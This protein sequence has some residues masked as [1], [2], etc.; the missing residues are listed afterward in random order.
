M[1]PRTSCERKGCEAF[2]PR[3]FPSLPPVFFSSTWSTICSVCGW[4]VVARD[5][6]VWREPAQTNETC[7]A[8]YLSFSF[9]RSPPHSPFFF[10]PFWWCL[11]GGKL[12]KTREQTNI[13]TTRNKT[14]P[15]VFVSFQRPRSPCAPSPLAPF[16]DPSLC[17][18]CRSRCRAATTSRR[19]RCVGL[20]A[21][22]RAVPEWG[23]G[24]VA[25][26]VR[27]CRRRTHA[28]ECM[29][30]CTHDAPRDGK[31]RWEDGSGCGAPTLFR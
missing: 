22:R 23:G 6:R 3:F 15:I 18:P 25:P 24:R 4:A 21:S 5:T 12:V 16:R 2:P 14:H 7:F 13:K 27:V 29:P 8:P 19:L 17:P 30:S 9:Q 10:F 11:W 31:R 28:A 26:C 1:A 20:V